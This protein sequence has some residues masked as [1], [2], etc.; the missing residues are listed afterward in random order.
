MIPIRDLLRIVFD[1][2][3]QVVREPWTLMPLALVVLL[4]SMQYRR[5]ARMER[6]LFGMVLHRP[7]DRLMVSLGAG[8][9]GGLVATVVFLFL[10]I[11]LPE[12]GI[13]PV[14]M[15]SLILMLIHPRFLCFSYSG[16]IVALSSLLFGVPNVNVGGLMGLVAVLHLVEAVL[17]RFTGA[18]DAMPIFVRHTDGQVVG[19]FALQRFWPMPFFAVLAI[20]IPEQMAVLGGGVAMP[21]WWPLIGFGSQVPAGHELMYY[22]LPVA[23][24][25][26]YGDLAVTKTPQEKARTTS[27]YLFLYSVGLLILAVLVPRHVA[28]A[29]AAA[30][31]SPL[32]HE[33]LIKMGQ[34]SERIGAPVYTNAHGPMV[35]AT[36]PGSV[37][38]SLGLQAGDIIHRV[39]GYRVRSREEINFAISPWALEVEMLVERPTGEQKVLRHHGKVPPLGLIMVPGPG[40]RSLVQFGRLGPLGRWLARLKTKF[41]V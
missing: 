18:R 9:V 36:L 31:F 35:L 12:T 33:F 39:N 34:R 40:E 29:Y 5:I 30:L 26:G 11:S 17:I 25:L 14:W 7:Q 16:G 24:A 10:G 41:S 23:A 2:L 3:L 6:A 37:A 27:N 19:G 15:L 28:W 1:T 22:L 21:D 32:A 13:L 20:A 8:L 38:H 4:I